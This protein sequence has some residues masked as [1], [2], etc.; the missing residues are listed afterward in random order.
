MSVRETAF[1]ELSAGLLARAPA[2]LGVSLWLDDEDSVFV[3][4][5]RGRVRQAGQVRR[6]VATLRIHDGVRQA[7]DTVTLTGDPAQ[8]APRL[9]AALVR[10]LPVLAASTPDPFLRLE[11][12]ALASRSVSGEAADPWALA[13]RVQAALAGQDAAAHLAAGPV[14]RGLAMSTGAF[15]WFEHASATLECSL[16]GSGDQAVKFTRTDAALSEAGLSAALTDA[17]RRL[18][19]LALPAIEVKPGAHRAL[20]EPAAC[21]DLLGMLQWGAFSLRELRTGQ[22]PLSALHE[23]R[24]RWHPMVTL[25]DLPE[26]LGAPR[27]QEDGFLAPAAQPLVEAGRAAGLLVSPR[28]Q[29][30]FGVPSTGADASESPQTLR[31]A[32]GAAG[33]GDPLAALGEGLWLGSLWYLNWSDRQ[34]ARVTGMSRNA[35]FVVREGRVAGPLAPARFDDGLHRLLGE[36]LEALGDTAVRHPDTASYERRATGAIEAPWMRVSG[37]RVAL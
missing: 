32:P 26:A 21:A 8:D 9:D 31:L 2:A 10:L 13:A 25:S 28:S 22:S 16:F 19:W 20:L 7:R 23:G 1:R 14:C 33:Q 37:L 6:C 35:C 18:D 11:A 34:E 24:C 36:A 3:R 15:H 4:F 17:R 30:E 5:N 12:R 29:A 27:F